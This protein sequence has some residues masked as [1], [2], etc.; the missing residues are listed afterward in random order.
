MNAMPRDVARRH[1][2]NLPVQQVREGERGADGHRRAV[3]GGVSGVGMFRFCLLT[4]ALCL[5]TGLLLSLLTP[6]P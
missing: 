4:L 6:M 1:P 5:L 3:R 2:A